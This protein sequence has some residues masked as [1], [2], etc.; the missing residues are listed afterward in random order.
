MIWYDNGGSYIAPEQVPIQYGGLSKGEEFDTKD[1]AT[2]IIMQPASKET[3]EFAVTEVNLL[4]F[5]TFRIL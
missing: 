2:Q 1:G 3:I 4:P 5:Y